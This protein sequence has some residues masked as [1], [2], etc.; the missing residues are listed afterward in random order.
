MNILLHFSRISSLYA[1]LFKT[2]HFRQ[3][4]ILNNHYLVISRSQFSRNWL[5]DKI[6]LFLCY[7]I[8]ANE[9][10]GF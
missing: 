7:E 1:S 3:L 2:I 9:N 4:I 5:Y 8:K 6:A 10:D